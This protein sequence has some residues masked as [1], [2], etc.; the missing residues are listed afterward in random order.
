MEQIHG[1][2]TWMDLKK[3]P[4][5]ALATYRIDINEL[6]SIIS[7]HSNL[8]L[9]PF[10]EKKLQDKCL[11]GLSHR[12]KQPL[13]PQGLFCPQPGLAPCRSLKTYFSLGIFTSSSSISTWPSL[14]DPARFGVRWTLLRQQCRG[15]GQCLRGQSCLRAHQHPAG[16]SMPLHWFFPGERL[17]PSFL[18]L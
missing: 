6:F 3:N 16:N 1:L 13:C 2:F 11:P 10:T 12:L 14:R 15:L 17:S 18:S 4:C 8:L 7:D 9:R 5:Y